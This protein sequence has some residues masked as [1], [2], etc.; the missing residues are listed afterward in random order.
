MPRVTFNGNPGEVFSNTTGKILY[1]FICNLANSCGV[2]IQ[3]HHAIGP[4][5]PLPIHRRCR[6][7]QRPVPP[8]HD[9]LPYVDFR[10]VIAGLDHQQQSVV[11]GRANLTLIERGVVQ[12]S[13]VVTPSRVRDLREVVAL[14]KLSIRS[15]VDAGVNRSQAEK[16]YAT[17]HT[18]NREIAVQHRK[19]FVDRMI[20]VGATKEDIAEFFGKGV[21]GRVTVSK[22]PGGSPPLPPTPP[23]SPVKPPPTP[24]SVKPKPKP[25]PELPPVKPTP[26]IKPP[27]PTISPVV[28]KQLGV[29]PPPAAA[30]ILPG[31]P[32]AERIK[33]DTHTAEKVRQL[34]T[35]KETLNN[36][37][38][39]WAEIDREHQSLVDEEA[40]K[41][42][43]LSAKKRA[44]LEELKP[45]L[46]EAWEAYHAEKQGLSAKVQ[47][48]L[49][50]KN[51]VKVAFRRD[52]DSWGFTPQPLS[53]DQNR[54]VDAAE[55]WLSRVIERGSGPAELSPHLT[56]I[57]AHEVQRSYHNGGQINLDDRSGPDVVVHEM[58]HAIDF[59]HMTDGI[60]VGKRS[61]EFLDYRITGETVRK[62]KDVYPN[63]NYGDDEMGCEDG[64]GAAFGESR[65]YVGK[66]Y[67]GGNS[68]EIL[69]MGMQKL[70][71][72]PIGF[73]QA[74]P[75]YC[76]F[77][78]GILH[79]TLR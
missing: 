72:D 25:K 47:G 6:C 37:R 69:A 17:V 54:H 5:W 52:E 40:W 79:G 20:A 44:R 68:N 67:K 48:I 27:P 29:K 56:A 13:D 12:W 58:G 51:P 19:A 1:Q 45:M 8:G 42:A 70:L 22:G 28:A 21:A 3:Y 7:T 66:V 43:K 65:W 63:S 15:M 41:G 50:A 73:A 32:I 16:A 23:P 46:S 33:E 9:A 26:S 11:V 2:C 35:V 53:F 75:E 76:Q 4:Y 30:P 64:F 24:P 77:V 71:N 10:E 14:K 78:L 36:L 31:R 59:M 74:D 61:R 55:A 62:F 60:H 38:R 39:R 57:K 49:D 18:P 34:A